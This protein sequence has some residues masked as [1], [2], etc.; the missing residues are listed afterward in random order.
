MSRKTE[1]F[2]VS[3]FGKFC[4]YRTDLNQF[5]TSAFSQE[6][7]QTEC[8]HCAL[9]ACD[10]LYFR[11]QSVSPNIPDISTS[12][13]DLIG[14]DGNRGNKQI[15]HIGNSLLLLLECGGRDSTELTFLLFGG[16]KHPSQ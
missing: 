4:G 9:S 14:F 8:K 3:A 15:L 10:N 11:N 7:I 2:L 6:K 16:L 12:S 5:H 13:I 1:H